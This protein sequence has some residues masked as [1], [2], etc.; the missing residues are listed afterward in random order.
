MANKTDDK[1]SKVKLKVNMH[2]EGDEVK[3]YNVP[4]IWKVKKVV[5]RLAVIYQ[6]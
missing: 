5:F 4:Y 2:Q 6:K 3:K 1:V